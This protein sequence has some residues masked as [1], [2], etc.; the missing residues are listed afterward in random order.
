MKDFLEIIR[1]S[2]VASKLP[3][4]ALKVFEEWKSRAVLVY[5]SDP[6]RTRSAP[7]GDVVDDF[8]GRLADALRS[9]VLDKPPEKKSIPGWS[10]GYVCGYVQSSLDVEWY[11]RFFFGTSQQIRTMMKVK[12]LAE[13]LRLEPGSIEKILRIYDYLEGRGLAPIDTASITDSDI[14]H[15]DD[16]RDRGSQSRARNERSRTELITYLENH[17]RKRYVAIM[18]SKRLECAP[19][20]GKYLTCQDVLEMVGK[21]HVENS[22]GC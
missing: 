17:L 6:F 7:S 16:F 15:L 22:V 1:S 21:E 8:A 10:Y 3:M 19:D 14:L 20:I 5:K 4:V 11:D 18:K 12:A 9:L 2:P 13:Y